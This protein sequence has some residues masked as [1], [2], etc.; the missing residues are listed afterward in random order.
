MSKAP[1]TEKWNWKSKR[2]LVMAFLDIMWAALLFINPATGIAVAP[3]MGGIN[4]VWLFG[5]SWR[6]SG[7]AE[8]MIQDLMDEGE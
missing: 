2:C 6:P 1:K 7:V 8:N 5:E 4:G 3:W